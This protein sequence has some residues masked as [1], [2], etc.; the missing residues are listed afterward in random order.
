MSLV[1][2]STH[3]LEDL[4]PNKGLSEREVRDLRTAFGLLDRNQDG[5]VTASELQFM[6]R[7]LGIHVRDE[8]IQDLM[9]D[10]S[11]SGSGL[12]DETEFLQWIAK[13]QAVQAMQG[14]TQRQGGDSDSNDDVNKDLRSAFKVFDR[15]GNGYI[16]RDELRTAMEMIGE[17]VTEQQVTELMTLADTDKDGRIN[18]EEF[19]RLFS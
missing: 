13:I 7:N 15:D 17:N 11:Q 10:A 16:S 19:A 8:L 12:I 1:S 18:F 2:N 9:K 6:L 5:H 4:M 3:T 14:G